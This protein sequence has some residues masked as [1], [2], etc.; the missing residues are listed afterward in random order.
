V[1]AR[2]SA[3]FPCLMKLPHA[4]S[5]RD[6]AGHRDAVRLTTKTS[7][8]PFLPPNTPPPRPSSPSHPIPVLSK[9]HALTL[10]A[11]GMR[12]GSVQ[13]TWSFI[14]VASDVWIASACAERQ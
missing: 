14:S 13:N 1:W 8:P 3:Q 6:L 11:I 7:L 5:R 10:P 2:A 4:P 12:C 9:Q